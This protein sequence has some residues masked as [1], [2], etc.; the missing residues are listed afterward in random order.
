M[1]RQVAALTVVVVL[2]GCS[3]SPDGAAGP[4][5]ATKSSASTPVGGPVTLLALGD[6]WPYGAHCNGCTPFP[7]LYAQGLE[8]E[9]GLEVDVLNLVTNGGT[10]ASL[11]Q[12]LTFDPAYSDA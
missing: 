8:K 4:A 9:L 5:P 11:R 3:A 7:E 2:G 1:R 6:S 12:S 10:S